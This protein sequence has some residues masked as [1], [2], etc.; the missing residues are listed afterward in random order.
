MYTMI[1]TRIHRI[2]RGIPARTNITLS[3]FICSIFHIKS[4]LKEDIS[5]TK[6]DME[7]K[8]RAHSDSV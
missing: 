4:Y 6:P 7:F 3:S 2:F 5:E 8:L 1:S